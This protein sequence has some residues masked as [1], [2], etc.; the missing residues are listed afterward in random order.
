MRVLA[1]RLEL[2]NE[3]LAEARGRLNGRLNGLLAGLAAPSGGEESGDAPGQPERHRDAA[4]L[5]SLPGVGTTN[6]AT[7][8]AEAPNA[9]RNGDD[10]ALRCLCGAARRRGGAGR[11]EWGRAG[12]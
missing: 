11:R 3:Q 12:R 4:V 10:H 5:L 1:K 7:L 8:L 2:V 9:L 6:A